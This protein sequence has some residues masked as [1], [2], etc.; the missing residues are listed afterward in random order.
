MNNFKPN[1]KALF[2]LEQSLEARNCGIPQ[3]LFSTTV[4]VSQRVQRVIQLLFLFSNR[5]SPAQS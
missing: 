1:V 2:S 3:D 5:I 4:Y